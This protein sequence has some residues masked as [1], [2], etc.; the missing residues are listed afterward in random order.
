MSGVIDALMGMKS[1][2]AADGIVSQWPL[3]EAGG[4]AHHFGL[5]APDEFSGLCNGNILYFLN[6]EGQKVYQTNIAL[7]LLTPGFVSLPSFFFSLFLLS[8]FFFLSFFLLFKMKPSH[9][10]YQRLL[11]SH[12]H[13]V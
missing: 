4:K 8:S 3:L 6:L 7:L 12:K 1:G 11:K 9:T 2:K 10:P 5:T 13:Q